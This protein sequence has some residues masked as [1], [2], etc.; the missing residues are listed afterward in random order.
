MKYSKEITNK[1]CNFIKIGVPN[2]YAAQAVGINP[3]TFYAWKNERSDF[4]DSVREAE[5]LRVAGLVHELRQAHTPIGIMWLL[6]R[7]AREEFGRESEKK[8]WD[9]IN[10]IKEALAIKTQGGSAATG[11]TMKP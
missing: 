6:E 9:E 3:D 10:K 7:V 1:I 4:S 5:G 8:L 11:G 2:K